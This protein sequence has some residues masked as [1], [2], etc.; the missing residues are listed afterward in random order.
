MSSHRIYATIC[1]PGDTT[2][3]TV[4]ADRTERINNSSELKL[5]IIKAV[6]FWIC[7]T[8]EGRESHERSYDF[9]PKNCSNY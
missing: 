4:I 1:R 7:K 3:A 2:V 8:K 5:A 6:T 9:L